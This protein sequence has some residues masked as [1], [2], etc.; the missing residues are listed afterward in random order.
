MGN[1][2]F[3]HVFR[4]AM[5]AGGRDSI[6]LKRLKN[7]TAIFVNQKTRKMQIAAYVQISQYPVAFPGVKNACLKWSWSQPVKQGWCQIPADIMHKLSDDSKFEW[8][9]FM[10]ELEEVFGALYSVGETVIADSAVVECDRLK[11]MTLWV[12]TTEKDVMTMIFSYPKLNNEKEREKQQDTVAEKIAECVAKQLLELVKMGST[13]L[14]RKNFPTLQGNPR[15]KLMISIVLLVRNEDWPIAAQPAVA[16]AEK[17]LAPHVVKFDAKGKALTELATI[18]K[19]EPVV[20]ILPWAKWVEVETK[21]AD[22][23]FAKL[24]LEIVLL[25]LHRTFMADPPNIAMIRQGKDIAMRT[26]ERFPKAKLVIPIFFRKANSMVMDGEQGGVR[27]RNG[28]NCPVHWTRRPVSKLDKEK[29]GNDVEDV[30]VNVFVGPEMKVPKGKPNEALEWTKS[31][32]LHPFWFVKRCQP[33][34]KSNMELIFLAASHII[35]CDCAALVQAGGSDMPVMEVAQ[36]EYACLVNTV[37]IEVDEEIILNWSQQAV[38]GPAKG[39]KQKNAFDQL[40]DM[41]AK[42]KK[43]K[44]NV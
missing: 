24:T 23:A 31:E 27:P 44:T 17:V 30:H 19:K 21:T 5:S 2:E 28:V 38:K 10:V 35:A 26:K 20:D 15:N 14:T 25:Q 3:V 13:R 43:A 39:P 40:K 7:F 34:D 33:W 6:W 8:C 42:A 32:E 36:V 9:E 11:Q 22:N 4:F 37:D 1:P 16:G 12:T 29:Y 41:E 18:Q